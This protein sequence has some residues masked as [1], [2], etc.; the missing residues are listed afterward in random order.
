MQTALQ[1]V[2]VAGGGYAGVLA[3]N[4][5]YNRLRG[6]ARVL[7]V[8]PDDF[9]LATGDLAALVELL[10][11]DA[12]L[13]TDHGG[14]VSAARKLL[15]GGEAVALFLRGLVLKGARTPEDYAAQVES[16]NGAPSVV[17]RT[18]SGQVLATF[19]L[20]ICEGD[21]GPRITGVSVMRNPDKLH[22]IERSLDT[23]E[24]LPVEPCCASR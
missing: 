24:R 16:L 22:R 23:G 3:A 18:R 17:L 20:R 7:L 11:E 9:A 14:K 15:Q 21:P 5:A 19:T 1:T 13:Q 8:T 12:T 10:A 6:R 2:I 4:R